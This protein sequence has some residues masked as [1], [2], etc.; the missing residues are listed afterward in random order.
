MSP[1]APDP[2][3]PGLCTLSSSLLT[4]TPLVISTCHIEMLRTPTLPTPDSHS[5]LSFDH[6]P[7]VSNRHLRFNVSKTKLLP[8]HL[9]PMRSAVS[10]AEK[11]ARGLGPSRCLWGVPREGLLLL[12]GAHTWQVMPGR[13]LAT[14]DSHS[15]GILPPPTPWASEMG[16]T[17]LSSSLRLPDR[18]VGPWIKGADG[19][20]TGR[21]RS[22]G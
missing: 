22:L 5:Q 8:P 16:F 3:V 17:L 14:S 7:R 10:Q 6:L 4:C 20:V 21:C 1:L 11:A 19:V 12:A 18:W 15:L 2:L 13:H 9:C